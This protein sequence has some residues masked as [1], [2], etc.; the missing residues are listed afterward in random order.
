MGEVRHPARSLVDAAGSSAGGESARLLQ[1]WVAL[2]E[3][4]RPV[5]L[6]DE[7]VVGVAIQTDLKMVSVFAQ[8]HTYELEM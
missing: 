1:R 8:E 5:D 7:T 4:R 6:I 3:K 2:Y